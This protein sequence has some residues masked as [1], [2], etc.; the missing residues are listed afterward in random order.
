MRL[1]AAGESPVQMYRFVRWG[2]WQWRRAGQAASSS[3]CCGVSL[4]MSCDRPSGRSIKGASCR[5]SHCTVDVDV[6][7]L[8]S[9]GPAPACPFDGGR[10]KAVGVFTAS[11]IFIGQFFVYLGLNILLIYSIPGT[12]L[13]YSTIMFPRLPLS[14]DFTTLMYSSQRHKTKYSCCLLCFNHTV[15]A[16]A[17]ESKYFTTDSRQA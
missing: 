9:C 6:G 13:L 14:T 8:N 16:S 1:V 12:I 17:S 7:S 15:V 4:Q 11:S 2:W 5:C 3:P 10:K